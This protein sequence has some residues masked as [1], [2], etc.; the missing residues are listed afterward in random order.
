MAAHA[1]SS[2]L[3]VAADAGARAAIAALEHWDAFAWAEDGPGDNVQA[4]QSVFG[5]GQWR[6]LLSGASDS[7]A[8]RAIESAARTAAT[9]AGLRIVIIEDLPGNYFAVAGSRVDLLVVESDEAARLARQRWGAAC[10][11]VEV[12]PSVRYD[13]H[14]RRLAKL[15]AAHARQADRAPA[16]L[17]AGQPETADCLRTLAALAPAVRAT[18]A[19]MLFKAHPRDRGYLGGAYPQALS[20][21]GLGFSDVTA[22]SVLEA[23]GLAP[24]LVVTQFSSVAVEA[25]FFG[26]PALHVLLPEAGGA[27]LREKKGYDVPPWCSAGAAFFA[28]NPVNIKEL[29]HSALYDEGQRRNIIARF[30]MY[31]SS[32]AEVL[33]ALIARLSRL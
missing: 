16:I 12:F 8:G 22:L 6:M 15:R 18:G 3:G 28:N 31:F 19:T 21:L 23:M 7:V 30:D 29:I 13:G 17:W 26:V 11:A 33:P 4:W 14:R 5:R 32:S 10:P 27:R 25:G 9:A 1:R 20:D 2:V 24:R